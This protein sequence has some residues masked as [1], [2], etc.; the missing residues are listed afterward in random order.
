MNDRWEVLWR[1]RNGHLFRTVVR[2]MAVAYGADCPACG[3]PYD[4]AFGQPKFNRCEIVDA[5]FES[6]QTGGYFS[7]LKRVMGIPEEVKVP[8]EVKP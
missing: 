6:D 8:D 3:A 4:Q 2:E 5:Y 1:C 7:D